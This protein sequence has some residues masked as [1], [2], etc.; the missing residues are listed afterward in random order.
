MSNFSIGLTGL[1]VAQQALDLIGTNISNAGTEGYHRQ[2]PVIAPLELGSMGSVSYGGAR[3]VDVTRCYN[4]LLE[5]ELLSQQPLMG[6]V[7][8]E[9][10][11]LQNIESSLG[12]LD[13]DNLTAGLHKFFNGLRELAS[14]PDSQA[15]Q[16]QA[17]WAADSV[18][19]Q[20][21]NL[22]DFM[23]RIHQ[24]IQQEASELA[25]RIN[26][27]ST[28]IAELNAD[29]ESAGARG[30]SGNILKDHRDQRINEL[31]EL[32]DVETEQQQDGRG[33]V[34][35]LAWG[36]PMVVGSNVS[37]VQ[38]DTLDDGRLGISLEGSSFYQDD[39]TGGT[40]GGLLALKNEILPALQDR[41]DTLARE[42]IASVNDYHVQGI[43]PN[44]SFTELSGWAVGESTAVSDW[45]SE[46]TD[47]T[48]QVRMTNTSTGEV[49]RHA[50]DVDV[51][52]GETLS[53]V[54]TKLD[55]ITGLN[56][57]V[58]DS[59]LHLAADSGYEFDFLPVVL[60]EPTASSLTG[61]ASPDIS[62]V[63]TG[64]ENE[65]LT[66]TIAGSQPAG[67]MVDIGGEEQLTLEVRNGSGDLIKTFNIGL[68]YAP[69]T[70]L[71]L[72][73]GIKLSMSAGTVGIGEDFEIDAWADTD[74]SGFLAG[75]GINTFFSGTS[76]S[77]ITVES[78]IMDEPG[79]FASGLSDAYAD[80]MNVSRMAEIG[81]TPSDNL[82][83]DSPT[84][85]FQTFVTS[86]GEAVNVRKGRLESLENITSQLLSQR[87]EI[88]GVDVNEQAAQLL[89]F[90]RMFQA[91]AKV[92][93]TQNQSLS[94]LMNI[95]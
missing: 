64:D 42:I 69:G 35:V 82:D 32:I 66:C 57:W 74:T 58:A 76:A 11:T 86:V 39:V 84:Q 47:G 54:A 93:G 18:T 19:Q 71:D 22:A 89:V 17:I 21:R 41:I 8:K 73:N 70:T 36:M 29:I 30:Q 43:G 12:E 53:D 46:V 92:I 95:L 25:G 2:R 80:N 10:F 34:N 90:E 31:A 75:A 16:E 5:S 50:V 49:T 60:P 48:I 88:S 7:N 33:G 40:I 68:D 23:T 14:K 81:D 9:L 27:L 6:Q 45:E 26:N 62:G 72:G 24:H 77:N 78:R 38:V 28:E 79:D 61:T 20:L 4:R 87:D 52:G 37:A 94:Y 59:A 3:I 91:C 1:E 63:F 44:G 65:T 51:T 13:A 56:A 85:Y 55:A 15:L 67:T 83:G